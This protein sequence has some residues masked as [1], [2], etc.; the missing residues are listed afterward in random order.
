MS[1]V[2]ARMIAA[3]RWEA[4][5]VATGSDCPMMIAVE[6]GEER[7]GTEVYT[8]KIVAR[9]QHRSGRSCRSRTVVIDVKGIRSRFVAKVPLR[10][11]TA[12]SARE[13]C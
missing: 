8:R 2:R 10:M 6:G 4:T 13:K 9:P 3:F 7:D 1:V 5:F 11:T 12:S